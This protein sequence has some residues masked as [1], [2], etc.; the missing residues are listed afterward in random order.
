MSYS[1]EIRIE[2]FYSLGV[3]IRL[4]AHVLCYLARL[5]IDFHI[6]CTSIYLMFLRSES[7]YQTATTCA[8]PDGRPGVQTPPLVNHKTMGFPSNTGPDPLE[9]Y[10]TTMLG[11][12]WSM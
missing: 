2:I 8:D 11:Q 7:N 6:H 10:K 3:R 5:D 1:V 9:N 4:L 12:H